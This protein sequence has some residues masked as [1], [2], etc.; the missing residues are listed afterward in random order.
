MTTGIRNKK[1]DT[2]IAI[3]MNLR[4]VKDMNTENIKLDVI[5][6]LYKLYIYTFIYIYR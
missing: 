4:N 6:H 2:H 5:A 1:A 3:R